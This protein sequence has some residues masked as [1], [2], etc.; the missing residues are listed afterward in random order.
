MGRGG[1]VALAVVGLALHAEPGEAKPSATQ[2]EVDAGRTPA[3][4]LPRPVEPHHE[5]AVETKTPDSGAREAFAPEA[6][7]ESPTRTKAR[8]AADPALSAGA[9]RGMAADQVQELSRAALTQVATAMSAIEENDHNR[10]DGALAEAATEL[11]QIYDAVPARD[12]LRL[13]WQADAV[14]ELA[15]ILAQ[16]HQ[17]AVY[18]DPEVVRSVDR[19]DE[20]ARTG[21]RAGAQENLVMAQRQLGEDVACA[22]IEDAYARVVAARAELRGGNSDRALRL[23]RQVPLVVDRVDVSAPM[24]PVRF[25]LRAAAA[26]AARGNWD[27]ARTLVN[28]AAGALEQIASAP[29]ASGVQNELKPVV[30][31]ARV[32]QKRFDSGRRVRPQQLHE[33]AQRTRTAL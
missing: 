9:G 17:Q 3:G 2:P 7:T 25:S 10:A 33:L 29:S 28:Q 19:A 26:A 18:L 21:D 16:A 27:Q 5:A 32:L 30:S 4:N 13:L 24:V 11:L 22:P 15:P 8:P 12:L 14:D 23:L 6:P 31:R 20:K 1:W